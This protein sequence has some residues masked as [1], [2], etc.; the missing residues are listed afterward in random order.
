MSLNRADLLSTGKIFLDTV[1]IAE[2][3]MWLFS[4]A[5]PSLKINEARLTDVISG[6]LVIFVAH[7]ADRLDL[8]LNFLAFCVD[9]YRN[10]NRLLWF[11]ILA[12]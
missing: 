8:D 1:E 12:R 7:A 10:L 6:L 4:V 11:V 2:T 3:D 9:L 5:L